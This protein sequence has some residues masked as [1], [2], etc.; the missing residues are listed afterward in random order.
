M[1]G[2][3][4]TLE[5]TEGAGK[6]T[7]VPYIKDFIESKGMI[8]ECVREPGGTAIAEQI[9][10]ILKT[11]CSEKMDNVTELLL[12]Y[13]AR[14]QLVNSYIK[15]KL[16]QGVCIVCDRHDLSTIAYQGGGRG[17]SMALIESIRN[18]ALGDF[19]PDLTLLMDIEP[20]AGMQRARSRGETDRFELEEL[21]FFTRVRESYLEAAKT[22]SEVE[23]IDSSKD[24]E[25]VRAAVTDIME[26][27]FNDKT[28]AMA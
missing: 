14:C 12:M 24:R 6:T 17:L 4:I 20:A 10:A 22:R 23:I 5:G 9:R 25:Q 11:P 1:Q 8:C 2:F 3:F 19:K 7:V 28:I 15:P 21:S 27:F 13:A 16:A 18:I 26:K